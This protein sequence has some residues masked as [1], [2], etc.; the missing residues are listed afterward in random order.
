MVKYYANKDWLR[1]K[2]VSDKMSASQ[3][4]EIAGVSE[5]TIHR[6]LTKFNLKRSR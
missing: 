1:K 4:A 6:Y 3:I 2:F 5:M